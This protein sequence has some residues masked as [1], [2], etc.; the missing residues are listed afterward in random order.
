MGKAL[1]MIGLQATAPGGGAA[2]TA[3]SG[4][5]LQVRDHRGSAY[6]LASGCAQQSGTSG[7]FRLTSPLMHDSTV[8]VQLRRPAGQGAVAKFGRGQKLFSQDQLTA[9]GSGSPGA[10]DIESQTLFA[11]YEDLPGVDANL[12]RRDEL[13]RRGEE[14]YSFSNTVVATAA[15]GYTGS[16]AINTLQDQL[17]ANREYAI[18]GSMIDAGVPTNAAIRYLGPDFGNLGI[19]VP[20]GAEIWSMARWFE[21]LSEDSELPTIPVFNAANKSLTFISLLAN[22]NGASVSVSTICVLLAPKARK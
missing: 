20:I 17:K 3:V 19:G 10:G 22:E 14:I 18:L 1:E 4:N 6:L 7:F 9:F 16:Q 13:M 11:Y 21:E 5:S 8:G 12:I 2:F 15:G